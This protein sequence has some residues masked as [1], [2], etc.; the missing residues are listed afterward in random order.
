MAEETVGEQNPCSCQPEVMDHEALA[1]HKAHPRALSPATTR[2]GYVCRSPG[3]ASHGHVPVMS[4]S[5]EQY[6]SLPT[7]VPVESTQFVHEADGVLPSAMQ[8]ASAAEVSS[9]CDAKSLQA[10][11]SAGL[12]FDDPPEEPVA[13]FAPSQPS[14]S[15]TRPKRSPSNAGHQTSKPLPSSPAQDPGPAR[16][17]SPKLS[18]TSGR[19]AAASLRPV[20]PSFLDPPWA[21][22]EVPFQCWSRP[23]TA[24][25]V[26]DEGDLAAAP[27][28]KFVDG[29]C[30]PLRPASSSTRLPPLSGGYR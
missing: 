7:P 17:G 21:R 25:T 30:I 16:L 14:N 8:G 10:R 22:N 11:C 15:P 6:A 28:Y 5:H 18:A 13:P 12:R 9:P 29:Q 24:S 3:K 2:G 26:C 1:L 20:T 4:M 23:G 19:C 27:K